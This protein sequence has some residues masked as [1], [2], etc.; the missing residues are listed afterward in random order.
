MKPPEDVETV[1]YTF[2]VP[3]DLWSEWK[4]TLPREAT[5][6]DRLQTLIELDA[7]RR[8]DLPDINDDERANLLRLKLGRCN[9]RA[10]TAATALENGNPDKALVTVDKITEISAPFA[11]ES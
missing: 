5:L 7:D 8:G 11:R 6:H 2:Y 3:K 1:S 9:A 4:N 10:K